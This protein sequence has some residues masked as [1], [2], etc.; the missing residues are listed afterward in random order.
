MPSTAVAAAQNS[1][2]RIKHKYKIK[3]AA[4][5]RARELQKIETQRRMQQSKKK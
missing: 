1:W 5:L 4:K 3:D 2:K